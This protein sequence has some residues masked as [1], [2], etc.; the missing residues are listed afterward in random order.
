MIMSARA[1]VGRACLTTTAAVLLWTQQA[2][3]QQKAADAI[4]EASIRGHMEFLAG[5]AMKGRGSGTEDEWRTAA[6]I[7]SHL[8]RLGLEPLGDNDGFVKQIETGRNSAIAPPVLSAGDIT[9]THGREM[10]VTALGRSASGPLVK[11]TP[12][13]TVAPG[14]VV[15]LT[16]SATI[17]AA[18]AATAVAILT[19]ESPQVRATWDTV[20]ARLPTAAI[21]RGGG[22]P[23]PTRIALNWEAYG[24]ISAQPAGAL[25]TIRAETKPGYTWNAIAR[26]TGRDPKLKDEV[27]LLSAHL[28][29]LGVRGTGGDAIFNGADDDASGSTAVLELAEA[30]SHADRPKRSVLFAWFGSEEAGGFGARDFLAHPPVPLTQIVANV[31]FEMIGNPDPLVPP[32]TLWL[33]GYDCSTLGP[34]LAKRGARVVADPHPDQGFFSRS[35]NIQL[36]RMGVVAQTISSFDAVAS[37]TYHKASDE[38]STIDFAHMHDAIQSMLAPVLWLSNSNYRPA[39]RSGKDP[40]QGGSCGA[41][42]GR[43]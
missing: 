19:P 41:R 43:G 33:T 8:R 13:M 26:L 18:S 5:D 16:G 15:L 31:E 17:D 3:L 14:S 10:I 21:A 2:S 40:S 35:D 36:A 42:Q 9:L 30:L 37:K 4:T 12:G 23:P 24:R 11:Y 27:I 28:D 29:H 34:D 25:I 6:Y 7:G 38:V 1:H 22:A 32:H 20:G 39:W